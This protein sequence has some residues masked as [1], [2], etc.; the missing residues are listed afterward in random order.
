MVAAPKNQ[1]SDSCFLEIE[2]EGLSYVGCL[3][4]DDLVFCGEIMKLL[5]GCCNR[6]IAEIGSI[7]L[8]HTREV[9]YFP[10]HDTKT[11]RWL[12]FSCSA[13]KRSISSLTFMSWVA[14]NFRASASICVPMSSLTESR[15]PG[16]VARSA[17]DAEIV[18]G[19]RS[20]RIC[21]T[22]ESESR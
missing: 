20:G 13:A 9:F 7:D 12:S 22:G 1:R 4:F 2:H 19:P 5:Q 8:A 14:A 11:H 3:L 6:P 18:A 21:C 15:M 16:K 17:N 10:H